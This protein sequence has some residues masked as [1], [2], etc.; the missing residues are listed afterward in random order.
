[1]AVQAAIMNHHFMPLYFPGSHVGFEKSYH[2]GVEFLGAVESAGDYKESSKD[3]LTFINSAS[4]NIKLA[5]DKPVKSKRKV[6]HRK[7]LQKQIKRCTG[8]IV[9]G[10]TS[11]GSPKGQLASPSSTS[12]QSYHCKPPPKRD[13]TQTNL[14]SKSLAALFDNTK[15]VRG[16]RCKKVPLRN[17]NLPPSFFTEPANCSSGLLPNSIA[18]LKEMEKGSQ[19]T[20]EYFDLLDSDYNSLISEQE[21]LQGAS[22]RIHQDITAEHSMYEPHHLLNGILYSDPWNPCNL[23]KKSPVGTCGAS[24]NENFKCLPMPG[25]VFT[26]HGDSSLPTGVEDNCSTLTSFTPCYSEC[27]LPQMFYDCS[28]GYNR[29]GYPVL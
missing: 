26:S 23:I 9:N 1:M 14:Q 3:L 16:E 11:Q 21:I 5:L 13:T 28:S 18:T 10:N 7:Y 24:P 19:E 12:P 25:T 2:E 6:N 4:S 27:S 8:M 29:I 20:M 15:E 17:R 22:V